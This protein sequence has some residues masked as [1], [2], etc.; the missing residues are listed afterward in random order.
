MQVG[1]K[2]AAAQR[3]PDFEAMVKHWSTEVNGT[4]IFCHE[5]ELSL[6]FAEEIQENHPLGEIQNGKSNLFFKVLTC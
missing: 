3:K 1:G 5:C 4:N 6:G 2:F